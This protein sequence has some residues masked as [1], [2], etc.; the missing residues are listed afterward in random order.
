MTSP[1]G[2]STTHLSVAAENIVAAQFAL[3]GFDVLEQAVRTKFFFDLG[4]AKSDGMLKLSVH[5]TFDGIWDVLTPYLEKRPHHPT[6]A[7]EYHRAIA[8]WL[9]RRGS[10]AICCL[11]KFESADLKTMPRI[12]L[13]SAVEIADR[14]HEITEQFGE[15]LLCEEYEIVDSY[16][17]RKV[18]SLP[19]KWRFS[20]GRITELMTSPERE[21]PLHFTSRRPAHVERVPN[22]IRQVA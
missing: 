15:S 8:L 19:P 17:A 4:V 2:L 10:K 18:E 16:G 14:L 6:S 11:V 1:H 3:Y 22:P 13:A 9:E 7:A 21:A 5:G 20:Y 12:Y